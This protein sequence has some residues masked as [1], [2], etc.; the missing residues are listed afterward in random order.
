MA[1]I[2]RG[3]VPV[4]MMKYS[5]MIESSLMSSR[6]IFDAFLSAAASTARRALSRVS[7]LVPPVG[8]GP[9]CGL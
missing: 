8:H 3:L 6:T 9:V 4:Q 5:A 2:W 1:L 7:S